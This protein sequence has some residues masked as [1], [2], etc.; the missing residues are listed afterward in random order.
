MKFKIGSMVKI[1]HCEYFNGMNA[2]IL[3]FN[4]NPNY[5]NEYE[6][7]LDCPGT[8]M[9]AREENL[10]LIETKQINNLYCSCGTQ[11]K[12]LVRVSNSLQFYICDNCKKE[13]RI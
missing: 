2:L 5:P 13:I 9:Y 11:I 8:P 4:N 6:I 7:L 1:V 12:K 3:N 10:E